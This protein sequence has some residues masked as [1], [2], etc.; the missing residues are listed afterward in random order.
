[1]FSVS[2]PTSILKENAEHF[3][4]IA[5]EFKLG[6]LLTESPH[7]KTRKLSEL[8]KNNLN[9]GFDV[10]KEIDTHTLNQILVHI[11]ELK[12][13]K[14]TIRK[15]IEDGAR[16]Y[17]CGCGATGRLSLSLETFW[18]EHYKNN[19]SLREKVISFMA[20]GDVAL[21]HSIEKFEDFPEFGERQL[22]ENH[23][24]ENDLLISCTEGGETPFVIGATNHAANFSK[25]N[26]YFLY[27]NPDETLKEVAT[28]SK[29]VL[30]NKAIKK[31]NLTVGQ[32]ALTGSTR[33]QAS[34]ILMAFVGFA[35]IYHDKSDEVMIGEIK[36]LIDYQKNFQY[37]L[38]SPFTK[39]EAAHYEKG[40]TILYDTESF[41]GIT[42]L[43]DTTERSPTFS[44]YSF[45]NQHDL[46][47]KPSLVYLYFSK[48]KTSEEAWLM[49]LKRKP[50]TFYWQEVTKQ[51]TAERLSGFQ[52]HHELILKREK[53]LNKKD[54]LFTIFGEK[55]VHFRFKSNDLK[56]D[57]TSLD[58]LSKHLMMKMLLNAH[59]TLLMGRLNRYEGNLM[60]W[61]RPSNYKLIDR[62]VR[63]VDIIL[64]EKGMNIPYEKLVHDCYELKDQISRN[65]AIVL[66]IIEKNIESKT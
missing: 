66:K 51:T 27:C 36:K 2:A 20:G 29:E 1:M 11:E 6:K 44:L 56:L 4:S 15:T 14:E 43:T 49:L 23:F 60:T 37:S 8:A 46:E 52:F 17:L 63:Y 50:R 30:D 18:R 34:T 40:E 10:F 32:M 9:E 53:Y 42:I 38:F 22:R 64:R 45:E 62:S 59:S 39:E 13:L 28:R 26:P 65:E 57:F 3:L 19:K 54:E 25:R 58:L 24:F 7:P 31:I 16:I 21:I 33:L 55:I 47:K 41:W 12:E 48:A 5:H 61:V 35:L